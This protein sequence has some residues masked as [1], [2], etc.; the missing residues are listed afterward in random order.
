MDDS[1]GLDPDEGDNASRATV[2]GHSTDPREFKP[3]LDKYASSFISS[4]AQPK[5]LANSLDSVALTLGMPFRGVGEPNEY[6]AINN[7]SPADASHPQAPHLVLEKIGP[8]FHRRNPNGVFPAP[9]RSPQSFAQLPFNTIGHLMASDPP[10]GRMYPSGY[11]NSD[12]NAPVDYTQD[13]LLWYGA[14]GSD[15]ADNLGPNVPEN[16]H[17]VGPTSRIQFSYTSPVV[18]N[19][20]AN[21]VAVPDWSGCIPQDADLGRDVPA[22]IPYGLLERPICQSIYRIYNQAQTS[23]S[24]PLSPLKS[25]FIPS[26]VAEF[27][28]Q[29]S[30]YDGYYPHPGSSSNAMNTSFPHVVFVPGAPVD[31]D[32]TVPPVDV[33]DGDP[34]S[35]MDCEP[36]SNEPNLIWGQGAALGIAFDNS[37]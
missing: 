37:R 10:A 28:Q 2:K 14:T 29:P 23:A 35:I 15:L 8:S 12:Q 32:M 11:W 18:S 26:V 9:D 3:L 13:P 25:S 31:S 27:N 30:Y 17:Y 19:M 34:V 16:G 22:Y 7:L 24:Q 6:P 21:P 1:E 5:H 20:P 33:R 36:P 4:G